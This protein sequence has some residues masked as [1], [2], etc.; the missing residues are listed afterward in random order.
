MI[1]ASMRRSLDHW[2]PFKGRVQAWVRTWL[3]PV[4]DSLNPLLNLVQAENR[5]VAQDVALLDVVEGLVV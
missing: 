5:A 2:E 3:E 1:P 4:T